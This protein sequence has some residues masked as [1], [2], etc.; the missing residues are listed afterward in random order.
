MLWWPSPYPHSA[1][2]WENLKQS[3]SFSEPKTRKFEAVQFFPPTVLVQ[4]VSCLQPGSVSS[5]DTLTWSTELALVLMLTTSVTEIRYQPG[6][7][8]SYVVMHRS[9]VTGLT[10]RKLITTQWGLQIDRVLAEKDKINTHIYTDC[11]LGFCF[12]REKIGSVVVCVVHG[13]C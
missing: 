7:R 12:R 9:S 1:D 11:S 4:M 6:S 5:N 10:H 3:Q 2:H 13:C 8:G